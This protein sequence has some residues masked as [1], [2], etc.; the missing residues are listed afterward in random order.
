MRILSGSGVEA[1]S[2][3][4]FAGLHQLLRPVL[5][6]VDDLPEVQRAALHGAFGLSADGVPDRFVVSMAVLGLLTAVAEEQ[7]LTCIVD[8]AHWLDRAS[9][10]ALVFAARRLQA[11]PV[12]VLAAAP[13]VEGRRFEAAGLPELPFA[14]L[15]QPLRPVLDRVDD[16]PEVQRAALH[17]ARELRGPARPPASPT[18]ARSPSSH[19]RS[20]RSPAWWPRAPRTRP[21]PLSSS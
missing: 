19:R 3:L 4:P 14:G 20:C 12:A 5:D 16:L 1:E 17:A 9:A 6:R 10:D 21:W 7:P 13:E 2:E 15:H 8:D 11:D 18:S